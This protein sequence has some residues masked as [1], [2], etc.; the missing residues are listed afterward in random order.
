MITIKIDKDLGT[1]FFTRKFINGYKTYAI[2]NASINFNTNTKEIT[3]GIQ[4]PIYPHA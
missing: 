3:N 1:F 2:K 4:L